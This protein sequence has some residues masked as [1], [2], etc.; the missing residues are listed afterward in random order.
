MCYCAYSVAIANPIIFQNC[1]SVSLS[2]NHIPKRAPNYYLTTLAVH[3]LSEKKTP[4][5][6]SRN[7]ITRYPQHNPGPNHNRPES[8]DSNNS[9]AKFFRLFHFLF[10]LQN[11]LSTQ[12]ILRV[13]HSTE[14]DL[15]FASPMSHFFLGLYAP[16]YGLTIVYR[17][18]QKSLW[19][20]PC[21]L[22][23]PLLCC[24]VPAAFWW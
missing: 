1:A 8:F 13:H 2:E 20:S 6:Y 15:S 3:S 14:A 7:L 19:N 16:M 4:K 22:S 24:L 18:K 11:V 17:S 9:S 10:P 21:A 5:S 23:W 12:P